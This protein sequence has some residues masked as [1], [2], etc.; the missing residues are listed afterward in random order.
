MGETIGGQDDH[1]FWVEIESRASDKTPKQVCFQFYMVGVKHFELAEMCVN[2]FPEIKTRI[3]LG[4][5][6][7][8]ERQNYIDQA[9]RHFLE[10]YPPKYQDKVNVSS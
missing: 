6:S 10:Q 9:S 2:Y 1:A 7:K 5:M 3:A 4:E 8:K